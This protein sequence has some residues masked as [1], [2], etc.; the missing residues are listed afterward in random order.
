[1]IKR[2]ELIGPGCLTKA[3]DDEPLFVLR[4][5]DELAPKIVR[6]W[7]LDYYNSKCFENHVANFKWE[8]NASQA[9]KYQEARALADQMEVWL[10]SR[11]PMTGAYAPSATCRHGIHPFDCP[12]CDP[13]SHS[14]G[15]VKS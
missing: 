2:L 11:L 6:A 14:S 4:A 8:L 5:N 15:E 1:M 13:H 12:R 3:K 10:R 7:A 9:A